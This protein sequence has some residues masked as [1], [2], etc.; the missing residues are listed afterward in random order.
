MSPKPHEPVSSS[1]RRKDGTLEGQPT[2]QCMPLW[3]LACDHPL[4][5]N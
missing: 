5:R 3:T 2:G 1:H 4:V